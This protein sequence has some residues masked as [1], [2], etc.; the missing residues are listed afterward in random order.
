[1]KTKILLFLFISVVLFAKNGSDLKSLDA[2]CRKGDA[3]SCYDIG[4]IYDKADIVKYN[5]HKVAFYY[6][7]ACDGKITDACY[8]L[9]VIYDEGTYGKNGIKIDETKSKAAYQKG[10]NFG[11]E[12]CCHALKRIQ[13]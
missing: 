11:G 12:D 6:D 13:P 9:G 5:P 1:M 7:K 4:L 3:K 10:C 8:S 2:Q